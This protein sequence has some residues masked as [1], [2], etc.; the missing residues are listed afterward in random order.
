MRGTKNDITTVEQA[1]KEDAAYRSQKRQAS[2]KHKKSRQDIVPEWFRER[3]QK[4]AQ[5]K[6]TPKSAKQEPVEE[7]WDEEVFAR[8]LALL[9]GQPV[10]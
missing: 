8:D 4:Q 2:Y 3:K 7:P 9:R 10:K 5:A 6:S 1:N